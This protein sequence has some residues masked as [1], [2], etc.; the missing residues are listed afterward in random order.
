MYAVMDDFSAHASA[1]VTVL[2]VIQE[3]VLRKA[4]N[5][6]LLPLLEQGNSSQIWEDANDLAYEN[7]NPMRSCFPCSS[8][9]RCQGFNFDEFE[10]E[11]Q[12]SGKY[13][14]MPLLYFLQD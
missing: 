10:K 4:K 7:H 12:K 11:Q 3:E 2:A 6:C 5:V 8:T 14:D 13:K 1:K 9:D